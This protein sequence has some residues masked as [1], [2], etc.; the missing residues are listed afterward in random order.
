MSDE[1]KQ[2]GFFDGNPKM[3][4]T[5][6]LVAGIAL[7]SVFGDL[8][9][10]AGGAKAGSG[11]LAAAADT[12]NDVVPAPAAAGKLAAVTKNDHIRGDIDAK[13]TVVEYSDYEC[14]FCE[15][16]HPT[17]LQIVEEYGD[18]VA[19]VYRHFPLSF[20]PEARPA[21]LAAECANDQGKFW[22]FT[23]EM[24]LNQDKLGESYYETVAKDLGLNVSEFRDCIETE[25]YGDKVDADAASGR[26]AG[27][28]GTPAT[29]V[30][31]QLV[32]GAVPFETFKQLIDAELE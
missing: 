16:H 30:N 7:T 21:A 17:M 4:F 8:N 25:K 22:E 28:N 19:W 12:G 11:N 10:A 1:T 13:V 14:P 31:G 24:Y 3:I 26:T 5:F 27:V 9:L 29:F 20:H 32:S 18:D 6:G 2:P 23:D 15:R